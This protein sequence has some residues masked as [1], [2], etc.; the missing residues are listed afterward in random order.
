LT[1]SVFQPVEIELPVMVIGRRGGS[2]YGEIRELF[3][4]AVILTV[5]T[6]AETYDNMLLTA[7]PHDE[8]PEEFDALT[9]TLQLREAIFVETTYGGAVQ[10]TPPPAQEPGDRHG[11][12][13]TPTARRRPANDARA[14]QR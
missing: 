1:T 7:M 14:G 11:P 5:Q 6:R 3:R 4:A 10:V 8:R 13:Q 9:I 2:L 12:A